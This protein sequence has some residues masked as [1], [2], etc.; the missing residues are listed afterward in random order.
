MKINKQDAEL[1]LMALP[2]VCAGIPL[3]T[4]LKRKLIELGQRVSVQLEQSK[5]D[6]E[7]QEQALYI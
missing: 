4:H 5:K 1:L 3:D 2:K 7:K 6:E